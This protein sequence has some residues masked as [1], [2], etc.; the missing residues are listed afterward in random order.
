MALR[1]YIG[2][3]MGPISQQHIDIMTR[4]GDGWRFVDAFLDRPEWVKCDAR[5]LDTKFLPDTVDTI[6]ASHLLEHIPLYE[7]EPMLKMWFG[8]LKQGGKLILNVPDFEWACDY[9]IKKHQD[10][11]YWDERDN[12]FYFTKDKM[13]EIFFG[14]QDGPGEFHYSGFTKEK[15]VNHLSRCGF[16][17]VG[18][19]KIWDAHSMQV[20][21]GEATK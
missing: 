10:P 21:Y 8:L 7:I 18:V 12:N 3:G 16:S 13:W 5:K 15:L 9:F 1:L 4:E 20:I 2:P 19:K 14:G 17:S 6:Y 11:N